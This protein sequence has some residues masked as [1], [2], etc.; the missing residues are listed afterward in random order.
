MEELLSGYV[1]PEAPRS[2]GSMRSGADLLGGRG[3]RGGRE[4]VDVPG[5]IAPLAPG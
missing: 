1:S 5:L 4:R 2:R 3:V